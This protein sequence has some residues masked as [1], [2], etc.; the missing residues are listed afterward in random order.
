VIVSFSSQ[1]GRVLR[2]KAQTKSTTA[3]MMLLPAILL[4]LHV[5]FLIQNHLLR[6]EVQIISTRSNVSSG[7]VVVAVGRG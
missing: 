4:L 5:P 3:L 7:V 6:G 2:R 1:R